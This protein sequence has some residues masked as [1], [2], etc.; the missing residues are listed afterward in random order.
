MAHIWF[1]GIILK[2]IKFWLETI[3]AFYTF[4]YNL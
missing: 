1:S 4:F 3:D 2:D